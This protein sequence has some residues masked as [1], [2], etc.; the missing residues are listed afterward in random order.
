MQDKVNEVLKRVEF[1]STMTER[2]FEN[3]RM[4]E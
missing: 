2:Y 4:R 1:L 3:D